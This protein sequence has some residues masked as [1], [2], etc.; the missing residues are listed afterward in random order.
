MIQWQSS[1]DSMVWINE[2]GATQDTFCS[3]PTQTLYLRAYALDGTCDTVWS[4]VAY[5]QVSP[6][7]VVDAGPDQVTCAGSTVLLGG[8]PTAS[9][10]IP[11]YTYAWAPGTGLSSATVANPT[12]TATA[13]QQYILTVT[14]VAGCSSMDTTSVDTS[15]MVVGGF[16]QFNYTGSIDTFIVP[17]CVTSLTVEAWGA[18]GGG[19][20][21]N[22]GKGARLRGD[23]TV[24]PGETLL[25]LV[26]Q[27]GLF[28]Y[29]YGGGGGSF[30]VKPDTTPMVIAGGGGGAEHNNAFPGYDALLTPSGQSIQNAVGGS[31][32]T[33]GQF[34]NPNTSGC[35]WPGGGGGGLLTDGGV[36]GDGGGF[37]FVNGGGGGTDPS[38]NCVVA[39]MGGFGGGGSGGNAGGGG[40]GYSGGA[41]GAN[42]GLVPDRGGGGGGSINNG[43]NPSNSAGVQTGNGKV[44]IT[45]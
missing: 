35:G 14:D 15:G 34:G 36:S 32:G 6:P 38:G 45:W 42:I 24:V 33:G 44:E 41:G 39:G 28:S 23:F 43:S 12:A 9:G 25:V 26:G 16:Q 11:P 7:L 4:D 27:Q 20:S 37:A 40:G 8:S 19:G 31:N 3:F 13:Y 21:N 1:P 18:Q 17:P 5:V 2:P 29:G 10:G 22:G 30:V